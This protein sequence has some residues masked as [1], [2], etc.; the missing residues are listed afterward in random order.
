MKKNGTN[1]NLLIVAASE[2]DA[3][4][5]YATRFIAPDSFIF[6]QI[7]GK[8]YLLMSD[9]EVDR[10]RSQATVDRVFSTS[11]LAKQILKKDGKRPGML[12]LIERFARDYRAEN[13]SVP[14]NFPIQYADLLRKRGLRLQY[15]SD[16]FFPKR[17]IK[18]KE[19][20][21]AIRR[22]ISQV[23]RA[24]GLAIETLRKAV[25]RKGKLYYH[26]ETLT[27]EAIKKIINVNLMEHNCIGAHSIVACG[28]QAVDPHQEGTG[29]L[30]AHQSIIM[31]IFPR[32]SES[33]YFA[34]FTRTVVRG[35]A[36]T[37]LK[38]MYAAVKEGQEIAFRSIRHGTDGSKIHQAIQ[39]QF[40]KLGFQTGVM[41]G[42]MQGFFHGTGHGLGLEIHEEPR[43][44]LGKD[45]LKAGHVVTVEPGLYYEGAGGVR[46]EDVVVVTRTG[47]TNLTR[48]P[49]Y[50]E[51]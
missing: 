2:N 7:R 12:D 36:G 9:L 20:V 30:Y 34:D 1:H 48:F 39:K 13:L 10:A 19:E 51:I 23:E 29:P 18:T 5:Y 24:V 6:F 41:G 43:I 49:K 26:G 38:A 11:A 32:D 4:L 33:R 47:C 28:E 45:I 22:A 40:E 16:P 14:T 21:Q 50:L 25:I 8:K 37:K 3:N 46:L 44:S 31:D 15:L 17:T 27:S 42:R 35:K